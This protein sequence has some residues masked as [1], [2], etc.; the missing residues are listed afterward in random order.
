MLQMARICGAAAEAGKRAA[1]L[2]ADNDDVN[3]I[4]AV[5]VEES[6]NNCSGQSSNSESN[7]GGAIV[8]SCNSGPP[9]EDDC[10]DTSLKLG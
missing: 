4:N 6:N 9:P 1:V 8:C 3:N 7:G 5:H 10:S 2:M